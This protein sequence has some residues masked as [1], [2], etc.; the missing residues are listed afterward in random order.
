MTSSCV[1]TTGPKEPA[2]SP[3]SENQ[4]DGTADDQ[5]VSLLNS[6]KWPDDGDLFLDEDKRR[7]QDLWAQQLPILKA[8][9]YEPDFVNGLDLAGKDEGNTDEKSGFVVPASKGKKDYY[10]RSIKKD[11]EEQHCIER[12]AQEYCFECPIADPVEIL[13]GPSS[14]SETQRALIVMRKMEQHWLTRLH[15]IAPED[16]MSALYVVH[17]VTRML[18]N[19]ARMHAVGVVHLDIRAANILVGTDGL[20]AFIDLGESV[21]LPDGVTTRICTAPVPG[22]RR[23]KPTYSYGYHSPQRCKNEPFDGRAADVFATGVFLKR[24][25][26]ATDAQ[27]VALAGYLP[28]IEELVTAMTSDE[29]SNRISS[30]A[31]YGVWAAMLLD[32]TALLE[33]GYAQR[34]PFP[35][36]PSTSG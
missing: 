1:Y 6:E 30:G 34:V 25:F 5:E 26:M 21:Y 33:D 10:V 14:S 27:R 24:C 9:G 28:Q 36:P 15:T 29:E 35:H 7:F 2:V 20:P 13:Y 4:W 12:L 31:A 11:S 22:T 8:K 3:S 16:T 19:V 17:S 32:R 23:I 18:Q